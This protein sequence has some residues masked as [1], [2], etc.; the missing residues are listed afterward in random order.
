MDEDLRKLLSK[1]L[2]DLSTFID[3]GRLAKRID[4]VIINENGRDMT[5]SMTRVSPL[6]LDKDGNILE[7]SSHNQNNNSNR[8]SSSLNNP[9]LPS[10]IIS[11][12]IHPSVSDTAQQDNN[13]YIS[14]ASPT[15]PTSS[16]MNPRVVDTEVSEQENGRAVYSVDLRKSHAHYLAK[17]IKKLILRLEPVEEQS[18]LLQAVDVFE[19]SAGDVSDLHEYITTLFQQFDENGRIVKI[20]KYVNQSVLAMAVT[21]LKFSVLNATSSLSP[22]ARMTRD[23]RTME[24]WRIIIKIT[25]DG[26]CVSHIRKEQSMQG[27]PTSADHWDVNWRLDIFFDIDMLNVNRSKVEVVDMNFGPDV[28]KDTK[29]ELTRLYYDFDLHA[30]EQRISMRRY[31]SRPMIPNLDLRSIHSTVPGGGHFTCGCVLS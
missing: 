7:S 5:N 11:A 16:Q 30:H 31:P 24:G 22:I 14:L 12:S 17:T 9:S 23:V 6:V 4:V 10:A 28:P 3:L 13:Q 20:F 15:A 18:K 1:P 25:T 26:I 21:S 2:K 29:K 27:T 8:N 19:S